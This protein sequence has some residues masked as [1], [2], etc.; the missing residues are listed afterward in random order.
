[1]TTSTQNASSSNSSGS[2]FQG[3]VDAVNVVR[4]GQGELPRYYA[5]SY[6]GIIKALLDLKKWGQAGNGD[7][8]DN[9]YPIT[10][11]DGNVTGGE[12][13]PPPDNGTLWFDTRQ[14]RLFVWIDDGFYQTN[15]ADG[16]PVVGENPPT[17]QVPGSTWYNTVTGTFYLWDG[18][19]WVAITSTAA[20]STA[21][22]Q[23][24]NPTTS[25]FGAANTII[26]EPVGNTQEDYN[27]WVYAA[28]MELE[29]AIEA[30]TSAEPLAM[31]TSLP[32][33]GTDGD[34]FYKTNNNTLFVYNNGSYH[35]AVPNQDIGN[36]SN[37]IAL[38]D[39]DVV[40]EADIAAL[41][42][43]VSGIQTSVTALQAQP[44]HTYTLGTATAQSQGDGFTPGI[45]LVDDEDTA[46]GLNISGV[47]SV[48]IIE[49]AN[50]I[51]IGIADTE[52]A[53][54]TVV[55]DYLTSTDKTELE[56]EITDIEST[57]ASFSIEQAAL[58]SEISAV[59]ATLQTLEAS[60]YGSRLS[61]AGGLLSGDL[62]IGGNRLHNIKEPVE[63]SDVATKGYSDGIDQGI[64][65]THVSRIDGIINSAKIR[66]DDISKA[67]FDFSD[68]KAYGINA[69]K[70]KTNTPSG[71]DSYAT[72]G[73]S[74]SPWEYSWSYGSQEAFN[75]IN[76]GTR[77]FGIQGQNTYAKNL[78]LCDLQSSANG[79]TYVNQVNVGTKLASLEASNTSLQTQL[80]AVSN[81]DSRDIFYSDTAPTDNLDD[82]DLWFDSINLR[83]NVRHMGVW[84]F[85]DR[86]EDT[87]LKSAMFNAVSTST[88][89]E[90]LKIKLS[91]A[92]L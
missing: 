68:A 36:D 90:T 17:S 18:S 5:P 67:G 75:W 55:S 48:A 50:G 65:N 72:F 43:D 51:T 41:E 46:T 80:A 54:A 26:T 39:K 4:A 53:L 60:G 8:P 32:T 59:T 1:M 15:G 81:P 85:P 31:G 21:T 38:Q 89:F 2:S 25:A 37:V 69:L 45:W 13:N 82:G 77:V 16:V 83:L 52:T 88:D 7:T 87:A 29:A 64:R 86:V 78:V 30:T 33:T 71:P 91:A 27:T 40:I 49:G 47:G 23:L 22:L 92:L 84:V 9:W 63:N 3:V 12:F 73:T 14:G 44:H 62:D 6:Q 28:V 61:T 20:F 10:D 35:K 34:F 66:N 74:E 70:F 58:V 42:S 57:I 56:T 76:N 79:P 11:E 24:A 19:S